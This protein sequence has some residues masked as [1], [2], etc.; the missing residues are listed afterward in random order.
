METRYAITGN[1]IVGTLATLMVSVTLGVWAAS[2]FLGEPMNW[3][4]AF[5][6][7]WGMATYAAVLRLVV[8]P[9]PVA[10]RC[11][12]PDQVAGKPHWWDEAHEQA[13]VASASDC[14]RCYSEAGG[15]LPVRMFLCPTCGNK[16]CP[17]A[18][19]HRLACTNSNEPNQEGSDY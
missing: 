6:M 19:D 17:K 5:H 7:A 8:D 2:A 14:R 12:R 9:L 10:K 3:K 1:G 13:K 15:R 11:Y 16:R 18:T 4:T